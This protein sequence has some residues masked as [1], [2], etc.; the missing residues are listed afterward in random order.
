MHE[1]CKEFGGMEVFMRNPGV[2]QVWIALPMYEILQLTSSPF[3]PGIQDRFNL[4]FFLAVND[5]GR[6]CEGCAICLRLLIR[7]EKV[8]V[9][10]VVNFH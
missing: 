3:P 1:F 4:V 9:E 5:R 6:T 8:H 7:K 10:D 2:I